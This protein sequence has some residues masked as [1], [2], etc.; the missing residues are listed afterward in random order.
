MGSNAGGAGRTGR[1]GA[2]RMV[3]GAV[4]ETA[5][6][7]LRRVSGGLARGGRVLSPVTTTAQAPGPASRQPAGTRPV[8]LLPGGPEGLT[9]DQTR[10][11]AGGQFMGTVSEREAVRVIRGEQGQASMVRRLNNS[12]PSVAGGTLTATNVGARPGG[13]R[14]ALERTA[15]RRRRTR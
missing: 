2:G 14:F 8:S 10:A 11:R 1:A 4:Q 3:G 6:A 7:R 15:G 9:R 12:G 5:N 13:N